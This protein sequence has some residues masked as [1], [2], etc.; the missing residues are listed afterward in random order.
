MCLEIFISCSCISIYSFSW[1]IW[2]LEYFNFHLDV[3]NLSIIFQLFMLFP[4]FVGAFL[5]L[6]FCWAFCWAFW[7]L[8]MLFYQ[9]FYQ[10]FLLS[11]LYFFNELSTELFYWAFY[12]PFPES[13]N[14]KLSLS[15]L[16]WFLL[17]FS[18]VLSHWVLLMSFEFPLS[19]ENFC[20]KLSEIFSIG[21]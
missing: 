6:V 20:T 5:K 8:T 14:I 1:E 12:W 16:Q 2:D 18:T 11:S 4:G 3:R 17:S 21:C 19:F 7:F 15:F 9:V 13:L 10:K